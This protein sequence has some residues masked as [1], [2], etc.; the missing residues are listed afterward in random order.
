MLWDI[1]FINKKKQ[2]ISYSVIPFQLANFSLNISAYLV[3]II[4][5]LSIISFSSTT[6]GL[7]PSFSTPILSIWNKLAQFSHFKYSPSW[8]KYALGEGLQ[9]WQV[10]NAILTSP[11][12][13]R[14]TINWI[15]TPSLL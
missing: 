4:I 3:F 15:I 9:A 1:L 8:T 5:L 13:P 10:L 7:H 12:V 11:S 14:T 2:L 6:I